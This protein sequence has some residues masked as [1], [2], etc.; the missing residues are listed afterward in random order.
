MTGNLAADF[1]GVSLFVKREEDTK[2][3][4][5]I[6]F[7]SFLFVAGFL[8][9]NL[10]IKKEV[11]FILGCRRN[12]LM[13]FGENTRFFLRCHVVVVVRKVTRSLFIGSDILVDFFWEIIA[14]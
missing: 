3:K 8:L 4:P 13:Y 14:T 7:E 10:K 12:L 5:W 1:P 6:D 11:R 2:D 9:F